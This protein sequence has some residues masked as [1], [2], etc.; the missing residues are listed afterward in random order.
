MAIVAVGFTFNNGR[1]FALASAGHSFRNGL[2]D[3]QNV[4]AVHDHAGDAIGTSPV[5]NMVQLAGFDEGCGHSVFVVLNH[6]NDRQIPFGSHVEGLMEVTGVGCAVAK[7]AEHYGIGAFNLLSQ[8]S[9]NGNRQVPANDTRGAQ[10]AMG[11]ISDVHG[12]ALTLTIAAGFTQ[13]LGHHLVV[14]FL[15]GLGGLGCHVAMRMGMTMTAVGA[16][17]EVTIINRANGTNSNSLFTGIKVGSALQYRCPQQ[18]GNIVSKAR[19]SII[20]ANRSSIAL[21]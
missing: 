9:T 21:W 20:A 13:N 18:T 1:T 10:V 3:F 2:S 4:H 6:E 5:S 15:L 14:M 12:T 8:A 11:H 17:D 16:G 19:I 7:E